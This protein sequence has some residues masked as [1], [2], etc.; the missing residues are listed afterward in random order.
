M[1]GVGLGIGAVGGIVAITKKNE[2]DSSC[3]NAACL[4]TEWATIDAAKSWATV[5]NVGFVLAGVGGA[6]TVI[7]VLIGPP[8]AKK[9][10]AYVVPELGA[11]WVGIHGA[12]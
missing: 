6:L 1:T 3:N 11:G 10:E 12:F 2:L 7:G 5:S 9:K 8:K 4:P